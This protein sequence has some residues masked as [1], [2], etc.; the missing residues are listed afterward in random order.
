[1]LVIIKYLGMFY[2][3]KR[4]SRVQLKTLQFDL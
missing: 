3:K 2:W 4:R 1:M